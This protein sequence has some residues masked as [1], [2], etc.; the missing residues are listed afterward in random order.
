[1]PLRQR[2]HIQNIRYLIKELE[3]WLNTLEQKPRSEDARELMKSIED[4][5][6]LE[7]LSD[8]VLD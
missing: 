4:E 8:M 1:M 6:L 5:G 3:R 7:V 2:E